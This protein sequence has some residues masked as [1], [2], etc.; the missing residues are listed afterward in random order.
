M[1]VE[2]VQNEKEKIKVSPQGWLALVIMLCMFSGFFANMEGPLQFLRVLDLNTLIG[3]F[4]TIGDTGANFMGSGGAGARDGFMFALSLAPGCKPSRRCSPP[5][6]GL[7][8][9]CPAAAVWLL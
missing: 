4:G 8:W 2:T 1:A 6:C 9:V 7:C 3:S 5:S